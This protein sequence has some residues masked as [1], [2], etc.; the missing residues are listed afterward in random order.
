M[1]AHGDQ[2]DI[3]GGFFHQLG[4]CDGIHRKAAQATTQVAPSVHIPVVPV[5]HQLLGGDVTQHGFAVLA[6]QVNHL[7]L[8]AFQGGFRQGLKA[9]QGQ[10]AF[11]RVHCP[12]ALGEG[13]GIEPLAGQH[14]VQPLLKGF[15]LGAEQAGFE[16]H[17]H[18]LDGHEGEHFVLA[19]PHARQFGRVLRC[20]QPVTVEVAVEHDGG[21][22]AVA[23]FGN[24][25]FECGKGNFKR[26]QNIFARQCSAVAEQCFVAVE[27]VNFGHEYSIIWMPQIGF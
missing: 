10:A 13:G 23:Q 6:V 27:A 9:G 26:G 16:L 12:H 8:L 2:V 1:L 15:E 17:D 5:V 20:V 25:T 22:Q 14:V 18:A 7:D 19:E 21:A 4:A 24:V 3:F 11:A